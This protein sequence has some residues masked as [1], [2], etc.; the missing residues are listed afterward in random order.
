M[1]TDKSYDEWKEC[2]L[3]N[4]G[5]EYRRY[6]QGK[7]WKVPYGMNETFRDQITGNHGAIKTMT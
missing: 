6:Y 4:L 3:L 7:W 2:K 5:V 1:Q